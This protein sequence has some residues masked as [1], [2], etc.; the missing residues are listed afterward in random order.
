MRRERVRVDKL[1]VDRGLAD[2][3]TRAQALIM[4][5]LVLVDE[6]RIDKPSDSV[7]LNAVIRIKGSDDPAARYV[8]RG[9]LKLEKALQHFSIDVKGLLCLDVGASTGGF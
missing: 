5:G 2:S 1:I 6:R 4:A 3:R 7:P 9:G 8:G